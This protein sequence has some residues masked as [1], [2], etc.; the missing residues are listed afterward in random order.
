MDAGASTEF[1]GPLQE[2]GLLGTGNVLPVGYT[3]WDCTSANAPEKAS[4]MG[5][6]DIP[7]DGDKWAFKY[8]DRGPSVCTDYPKSA[9]AR[10]PLRAGGIAGNDPISYTYIYSLSTG[11]GKPSYFLEEQ[12]RALQTLFANKGKAAIEKWLPWAAYESAINVGTDGAVPFQTRLLAMQELY[13]P[14]GGGVVPKDTYEI[15]LEDIRA[16]K[17]KFQL[18]LKTGQ[19]ALQDFPFEP[20]TKVYFTAGKM[21]FPLEYLKQSSSSDNKDPQVVP[22]A[23]AGQSSMLRLENV[24]G[25]VRYVIVM[26]VEHTIENTACHH[27]MGLDAFIDLQQDLGIDPKTAGLADSDNNG[28]GGEGTEQA[29]KSIMVYP[30]SIPLQ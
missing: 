28:C 29:I 2:A 13:K 15:Q 11:K 9:P 30:I 27:E 14:K 12:V 7:F 20:D 26:M 4:A 22:P 24:K 3:L 6:V 19:M 1:G 10:Y 23:Y 18:L 5:G 21:I 8:Y 16:A 25:V 17:G